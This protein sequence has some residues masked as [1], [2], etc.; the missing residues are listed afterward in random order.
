MLDSAATAEAIVEYPGQLKVNDELPPEEM[1]NIM[2]SPAL[3]VTGS[4][5]ASVVAADALVAPAEPLHA[6][7]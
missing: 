4:V 3:A 1:L 7:I 2:I 6:I 5:T